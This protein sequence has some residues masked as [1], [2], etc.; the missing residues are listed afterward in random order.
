MLG[1]HQIKHLLALIA[2]KCFPAQVAGQGATWPEFLGRLLRSPVLGCLLV[3]SA[4]PMWATKRLS[5][6]E[7]F[8]N[9]ADFPDTSFVV[10]A[11]AGAPARLVPWYYNL[12]DYQAFLQKHERFGVWEWGDPAR[13]K[14]IHILPIEPGIIVALKVMRRVLNAPLS[15]VTLVGIQLG[16]DAIALVLVGWLAFQFGGM[17]GTFLAVWLYASWGEVARVCVMPFY[18][19]WPIPFS[20]AYSAIALR[21]ERAGRR[22]SALAWAVALGVTVGSWCWFRGTGVS[23]L[24]LT[25]L[26]AFLLA[27]EKTWRKPAAVAAFAGLALVLAPAAVHNLPRSGT[28]FPRAQVWHDLYIGIGTRPNPYGIRHRDE[29]AMAVAQERHGTV[30]Q[31]PGYEE[32]LRQEYLKILK[33]DPGLIARNVVLNFWDSLRGWC[34]ARTPYGLQAWIWLVAVGAVALSWLTRSSMARPMTAV[35][36]VWWIQ[37]LTLSLVARPQGIYLWET[38]GSM[39]LSGA[40]S[41]G[42]LTL[43]VFDRASRTWRRRDPVVSMPVEI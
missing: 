36:A 11:A 20:L 17:P 31:A 38:L 7:A 35:V 10:L 30:F 6:W 40:A 37:C 26:A 9:T 12:T 15:L 24:A 32:G 16:V 5:A 8:R 27:R 34:F 43:A 2:R 1:F 3:L 33:A 22:A 14:Y 13:A 28:I 42:F 25:P 39:I 29:F 23:V 41:A 19:Y 18:Y 21:L 4:L